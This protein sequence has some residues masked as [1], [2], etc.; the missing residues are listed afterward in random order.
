LAL[1]FEL[2]N[3]SPVFHDFHQLVSALITQIDG[4]YSLTL[5]CVHSTLRQSS[6]GIHIGSIL[7]IILL[8]GGYTVLSSGQFGAQGAHPDIFVAMATNIAA[9]DFATA[10]HVFL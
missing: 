3:N 8:L 6:R 9:M 5:T 7:E 4:V 1:A 2:F 10:D